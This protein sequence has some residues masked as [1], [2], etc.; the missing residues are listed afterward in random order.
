MMSPQIL[1]SVA[2]AL[3]CLGVYGAITRKNAVGMLL[4]VE[5]MANAA[6]INLIV[7]SAH[8]AGVDAQVLTLFAI[9]LTVVE[10]AVGLAVVVLLYRA[11]RDILTDLASEM[12]G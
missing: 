7:F 11:K 12:K 4:S 2:A 10:V 1:L 9:A 3:F 6:N 8:G 5:L